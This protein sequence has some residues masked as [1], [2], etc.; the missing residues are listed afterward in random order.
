MLYK[1]SIL[2]ICKRD[3]GKNTWYIQINRLKF[4]LKTVLVLS[5]KDNVKKNTSTNLSQVG[6]KSKS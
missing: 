5:L 4:C 3:I 2:D 6:E 1:I